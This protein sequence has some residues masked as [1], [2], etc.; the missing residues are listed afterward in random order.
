M[1][2]ADVMIGVVEGALDAVHEHG[3]GLTLHGLVLVEDA[4]PPRLAFQQH[5]TNAAHR[6][7]D[8]V[9]VFT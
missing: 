9:L 2:L 4:S 5:V 8:D 1:T 6:R 3:D 7:V